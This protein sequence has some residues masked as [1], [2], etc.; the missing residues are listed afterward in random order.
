MHDNESGGT[1]GF[2]LWPRVLPKV[3]GNKAIVGGYP[4]ERRLLGAGHGDYN[5][6]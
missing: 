4:D 5:G 2:G 3:I 6:N 1:D